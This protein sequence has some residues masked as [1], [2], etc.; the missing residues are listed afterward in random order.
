VGSVVGTHS[1]GRAS[2]DSERFSKRVILAWNGP[3]PTNAANNL[4]E[5]SLD[6]R[7]SGREKWDFLH[8]S[9]EKKRLNVTSTS[10]VL[11]RIDEKKGRLMV[12]FPIATYTNPNF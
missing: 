2:M 4:I 1:Q 9:K 8:R 5:K 7:F 6:R 3:S 10:K 12:I 11:L